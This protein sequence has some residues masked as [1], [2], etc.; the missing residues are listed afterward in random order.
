M[1]LNVWNAITLDVGIAVWPLPRLENIFLSDKISEGNNH[2]R[3]HSCLLTA[4]LIGS[5]SSNVLRPVLQ[6]TFSDVSISIYFKTTI[7][8]MHSFF[9][10]FSFVL[11]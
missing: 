4:D 5:L 7:S 1:F 9:P 8:T 2:Q 3:I 11:F 6:Y 10:T